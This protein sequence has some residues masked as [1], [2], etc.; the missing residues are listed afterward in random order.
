MLINLFCYNKKSLEEREISNQIYFVGFYLQEN[1]EMFSSVL[2]CHNNFFFFWLCCQAGV[3]WHVL[4]SQQPLP[5]EFNQLLCLSLLNSL[6]YRHI[7]KKCILNF[8]FRD[9]VL[10]CCPGWS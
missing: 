7:F 9:R 5:P 6:D 4:G 10:P 3:Q 2:L 1:L 8:F